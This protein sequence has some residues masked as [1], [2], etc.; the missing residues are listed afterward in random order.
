MK[1][2]E[3]SNE[4]VEAFDKLSQ[5][6]NIDNE[7]IENSLLPISQNFLNK[8]I[9]IAAYIKNI[10]SETKMM[11]EYIKKMTERKKQNQN[12]IKNIKN[13][14]RFNMEKTNINKIKSP[15][16][17]ITL[18]EETSSVEIINENE[19]SIEFCRKVE[20]WEP[21]KIKIKNAI[22]NGQFV[23]GAV[24]NKKRKLIIK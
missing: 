13:Y 12:K 15:E 20:K 1:L 7:T 11:Q 24:I 22:E 19:L 17:Y 5:I 8:S 16:F 18:G 2:Y 14:L 21:D 9:N 4:Y 23:H 6:E 3:I 10:E